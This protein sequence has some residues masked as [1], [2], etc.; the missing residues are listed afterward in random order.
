MSKWQE[1]YKKLKADFP[2]EAYSEDRSRG[3]SLTSLKAQYIVERL[4]E[5]VGID[6]WELTGEF[7]EVDGGV[8]YFGKLTLHVDGKSVTKE[9]QGFSK[10]KNNVG[11]M[12]K[13]ART[14][15]LSKAASH[16]G[17]GDAMYK[18]LIKPPTGAAK[19]PMKPKRSVPQVETPDDF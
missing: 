16:F 3:F 19:A 11:D 13:S 2:T 8:L 15:A 6:G 9:G 1:I 7:K 5:T 18:G 4:N 10:D 17:V 12:Y 14:E